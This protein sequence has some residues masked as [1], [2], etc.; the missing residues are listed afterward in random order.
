[1]RS[2]TAIVDFETRSKLN[3]KTVGAWR[4]SMHPSTQPL[5]IGY[6]IDQRPIKLWTPDNPPPYD[7]LDAVNCGAIFEAHNVFFEWCIW[8]NVMAARYGWPELQFD[9]VV[10][11]AARAAVACLPRSLEGALRSIGAKAQKTDNSAMLKLCKPRRPTKKDPRV[12]HDDPALFEKLYRYCKDDV[13]GERE[14]SETVSALPR[15]EREI[16]LADLAVNLR[17]I[18][19]D[20]DFVQAGF[21]VAKGIGREKDA[22]L[23]KLTRG[24]VMAATERDRIVDF[25]RSTGLT[26]SSIN[27]Q[28][29]DDLL[30]RKDLTRTQRDVLTLRR[31]GSR[32]STAKYASFINC[33][34]GGAVRGLYVYYGANAHG[35][36][37]AKLVQPQNFPRGGA[38]PAGKKL[39]KNESIEYMVSQIK[40]AARTKNYAALSENFCVEQS[41]IPGD[42]RGGKR[43]V[44]AAADEVLSTALRGAFIARDGKTFGVGDYSAIEARTLFWLADEERGLEIYRASGDIY[45]DMGSVIFNKPA[46]DL[47]EF[48]ERMLGKTVVLGCG[49]EMGAPKFQ[50]TCKRSYQLDLPM[51]LCQQA[52]TAYRDRYPRVPEL[53][54]TLDRAARRCIRTGVDV[55][56]SRGRL[57]FS[58]R[59]DTL[60]ITLP[61]GREIYHRH[62]RVKHGEIC[63]VDGKG[64]E[65]T[66]YGGKL[67]EYVVS[68]TARDMLADAL[69]KAEFYR[70]DIDPVMHSHDEIVCEGEPGRAAQAVYEVMIDQPG[71][72]A[73]LPIEVEVWEHTRYRK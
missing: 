69:V 41:V 31:D 48:F 33:V 19:V 38:K 27:H 40:D 14:L 68:G 21:D 70:D 42:P 44:P 6:A 67:T 72:S 23:T 43:L 45:R 66:T 1:M 63:F 9:R 47:N 49:Y 30:N 3:L 10:C 60:V 53:W 50:A 26:V 2:W 12:W 25:L 51:E 52:V 32:S 11:S 39:S 4:Y 71:W 17:G 20:T 65:D 61:S 46:E 18:R 22:A 56:A 24:A 62:A 29:V 64:R 15:F 58:M 55:E 37:S 73:G 34:E 7:L 28:S 13:V 16:F 5:C 8:Q 54:R 57:R 35:R 59:G 36:W